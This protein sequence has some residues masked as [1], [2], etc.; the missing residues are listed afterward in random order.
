LRRIT[1]AFKACRSREFAITLGLPKAGKI[2]RRNCSTDGS[3]HKS[4]RVRKKDF[5]VSEPSKSSSP[6]DRALTEQLADELL[7]RTVAA[8]LPPGWD[9]LEPDERLRRCANP[10]QVLA[11][12]VNMFGAAVLIDLGLAILSDDGRLVPS[13]ALSRTLFFL[14]RGDAPAEPVHVET[15]AETLFG[16]P[17]ALLTTGVTRVQNGAPGT[18]PIVIVTCDIAAVI[19]A[20]AGL[21]V[22]PAVGLTTITAAQ[23]AENFPV[24]TIKTGGKFLHRQILVAFD[25]AAMRPVVPAGVTPIVDRVQKLKTFQEFDERLMLWRPTPSEFTQ[26]QNAFELRE[27]EHV[28]RLLKQSAENA[29]MTLEDFAYEL[30]QQ[31]PV[32]LAARQ[33]NLRQ[34]IRQARVLGSSIEVRRALELLR[35]EYLNCYA[36]FENDSS[37]TTPLDRARRATLSQLMQGRFDV[38]PEVVLARRMIRGDVHAEL[39]VSSAAERRETLQT[40]MLLEKLAK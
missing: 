34:A 27:A 35:D 4:S 24:P 38:L 16:K 9:F 6:E 11:T 25:L 8:P 40:L 39:E 23:C 22:L 37:T 2:L 14:R 15:Q 7:G 12:L 17:P 31:Q 20:A 29:N 33:R 21:D 32:G 19:L 13:V 30:S 10:S 5:P 26:L 3:G 36:C 18:R 1:D 28:K